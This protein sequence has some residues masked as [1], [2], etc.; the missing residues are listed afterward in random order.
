[1]ANIMQQ[2]GVAD[3]GWELNGPP[4]ARCMYKVMDLEVRSDNNSLQ[5]HICQV[6]GN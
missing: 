2:G 5:Q 6:L 1:M 3:D 4:T